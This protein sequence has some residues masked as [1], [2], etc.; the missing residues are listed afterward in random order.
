LIVATEVML[1]LKLDLVEFVPA[2]QPPHKPEQHLSSDTD[3][4][5]ML[6]LAIR[7]RSRFSINTTDL[8]RSGPSF[9]ADLLPQLQAQ[10]SGS[11]LF[12][13][14]G[15]DSLRDFHTWRDPDRIL[16]QARL[17]VVSRPAVDLNLEEVESRVPGVTERLELIESPQVEISSTEIRERAWQG[18]PIWYQVPRE[19]ENYILDNGVYGTPD[20]NVD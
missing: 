2:G 20:S 5:Q 15:A 11:E 6:R 16:E 9:T 13:I 18:L 10:H 4:L 12:F 8:E 1:A 14:M 19:V 7:D 3:R 17:A